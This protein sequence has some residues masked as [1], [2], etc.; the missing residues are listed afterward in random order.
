MLAK[1]SDHSM[2]MQG[3][4]SRASALLQWISVSAHMCGIQKIRRSRL[5][6]EGVGTAGI[7]AADHGG[8]RADYPTSSRRDG[9]E[10]HLL[11]SPPTALLDH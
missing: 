10:I 4:Q 3:T 5:A 7:N 2:P 9:R 1:A 6:G 8:K 11:Y